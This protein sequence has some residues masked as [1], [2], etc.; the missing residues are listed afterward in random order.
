MHSPSSFLFFFSSPNECTSVLSL[1][2]ALLGPSA[3]RRI[4]RHKKVSLIVPPGTELT[5]RRVVVCS[6]EMT[7]KNGRTDEQTSERERTDANLLSLVR[8][9]AAVVTDSQ[10]M[11]FRKRPSS[12]PDDDDD[13]DDDDDRQT[14]SHSRSV[15]RSVLLFVETKTL[16]FCRRF[17]LLSLSLFISCWARSTV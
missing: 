11:K 1:F 10:G 9:F 15:G 16:R 6:W 14:D 17:P 4:K 2:L 5:P 12:L 8:S 7:S 13:D 3:F